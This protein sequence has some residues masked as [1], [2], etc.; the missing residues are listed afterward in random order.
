MSAVAAGATG[1]LQ[2]ETDREPLLAAVRGAYR[3]EF[4]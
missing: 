4:V 2:K 1:Y 3:D